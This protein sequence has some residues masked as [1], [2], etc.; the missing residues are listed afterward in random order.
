MG[1]QTDKQL[2]HHLLAHHK[3]GYS[4]RYVIITSRYRYM[5]TFC[6]ASIVALFWWHTNNSALKACCTFAI[7]M[8]AG[9]ILRDIGFLRRLKR[10]WPFTEKVVNW[11]RVD[12]IAGKDESSWPRKGI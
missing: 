4:F 2:A 6:Y 8:L 11:N 1:R 3:N 7:G 10:N 5:I 9:A 12:E